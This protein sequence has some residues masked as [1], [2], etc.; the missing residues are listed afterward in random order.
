[1]V[2]VE[3]EIV[4]ASNIW[5]NAI[6]ILKGYLTIFYTGYY[7]FGA[8]VIKIRTFFQ[9]GGEYDVCVLHESKICRVYQVNNSGFWVII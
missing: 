6:C 3:L 9:I 1:M 7:L 2:G 8:T 4:Q 5:I